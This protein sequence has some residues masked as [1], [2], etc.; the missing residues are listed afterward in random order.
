MGENEIYDYKSCDF[1]LSFLSTDEEQYI[2]YR[3]AYWGYLSEEGYDEYDE[4]YM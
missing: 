1:E 2:D 4:N 3:N